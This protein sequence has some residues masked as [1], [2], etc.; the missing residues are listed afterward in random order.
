MIG[1]N[2][3][4]QK[5]EMTARVDE[6]RNLHSY[7]IRCKH[8]RPEDI[9]LLTDD[10]NGV[11]GQPTREHIIKALTWLSAKAYQDEKIVVYYSGHGKM[12]VKG[13]K[14]S[15]SD[16]GKGSVAVVG[17]DEEGET[18]YPV[19]FRCFREGTIRPEVTEDL[20]EP[21]RRKGAKLTIIMDT[22]GGVV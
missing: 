18:M 15:S 13:K 17:G 12:G 4:N 21:A 2:Y 16:K 9:I 6:A 20:L 19:D 14:R 3:F 7:L 1:I 5:G 22:H 8:Y 11:F 10:Q